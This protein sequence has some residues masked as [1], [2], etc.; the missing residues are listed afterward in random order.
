MVSTQSCGKKKWL[1]TR[2]HYKLQF[3]RVLW[4]RYN[5]NSLLFRQVEAC[6]SNFMSVTPFVVCILTSS[7]QP[8][9]EGL[10]YPYNIFSQP[11]GNTCRVS[12][13]ESGGATWPNRS[14]CHNTPN[15]STQ[16]RR[17][18]NDHHYQTHY[19]KEKRVCRLVSYDRS[20]NINWLVFHSLVM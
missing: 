5:P 13:I 15:N 19:K 14:L 20:T 18:G 9:P 4:K 11:M 3:Y 7:P 1:Q 17:P 8:F 16:L 2:P 12:P 10:I 6:E